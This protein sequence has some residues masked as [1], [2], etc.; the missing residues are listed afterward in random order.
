MEAGT[1][2]PVFVDLVCVG[3]IPLW[4]CNTGVSLEEQLLGGFFPST[5]PAC[6]RFSDCTSVACCAASE[7]WSLFCCSSCD[8]PQG[9]DKNRSIK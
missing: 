7:R 3:D 1:C 5:V 8:S 2:R 6:I 9:G 4:L